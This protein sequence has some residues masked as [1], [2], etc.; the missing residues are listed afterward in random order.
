MNFPSTE[1][2]WLIPTT[3][4]ACVRLRASVVCLLQLALKAAAASAAAVAAS[5]RVDIYSPGRA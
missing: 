5:D 3:A 1:K 2:I 4:D